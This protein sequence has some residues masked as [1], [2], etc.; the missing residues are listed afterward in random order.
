MKERRERG[1]GRQRRE[2]ENQRQ[3]NY[4][5]LVFI[6]YFDV[7]LLA[8]TVFHKNVITNEIKVSHY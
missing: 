7:Y 2:R 1:E 8:D 4:F 3:N 6:I 5:I